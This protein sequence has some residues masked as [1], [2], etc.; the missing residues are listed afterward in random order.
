MPV[1]LFSVRGHD[2]AAFFK[3]NLTVAGIG[4][5]LRQESWSNVNSFFTGWKTLGDPHPLAGYFKDSLGI[6]HLRG[7]VEGG[8]NPDIFHLPL[9]YRPGSRSVH[10]VLTSGNQI[11]RI[12]VLKD[13]V[14]RRESGGLGW[15]SLDGITFRAEA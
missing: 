4:T 13:G 15:Y 14:V 6:V 9:E 10:M 1:S 5:T 2:G 11:G 8:P 7:M 12:D 3:G